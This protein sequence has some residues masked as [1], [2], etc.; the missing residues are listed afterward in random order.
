MKMFY[1]K[2]SCQVEVYDF[3]TDHAGK[4]TALIFNP[5]LA[6]RQHGNGWVKVKF[7]DLVPMEYYSEFGD[8]KGYTS[9]TK[10][11]KLKER[12]KLVNPSWQCSDGI[13]FTDIDLAAY[14]ESVLMSKTANEA[15]ADDVCD[16]VEVSE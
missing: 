7:S 13:Q 6:G 10:L 11:N 3:V 9:K 2:D 8:D 4:T 15:G 1:K 14:H 12:L 5:S 16:S